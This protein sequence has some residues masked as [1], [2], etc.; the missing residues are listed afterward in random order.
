MD[1]CVTRSGPLCTTISSAEYSLTDYCVV[2]F[3]YARTTLLLD[4]VKHFP[5][6]LSVCIDTREAFALRAMFDLLLWNR[7]KKHGKT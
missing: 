4:S 6:C 5:S 1:C 3:S 2:C 7:K